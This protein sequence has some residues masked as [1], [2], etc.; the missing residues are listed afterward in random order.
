MKTIIA[1]CLFLALPAIAENS[2]S[3]DQYK[4]TGQFN[5]DNSLHT[6]IKSDT[7]MDFSTGM[8]GAN[9]SMYGIAR[10]NGNP[11]N[12]GV[13]DIVGVHGTAIKHGIFWAAGMH[14][15]VYDTSPGGT[16]VCLNVEFPQT[17]RGTNTIGINMQPHILARDLV[18]MQIQNP[19]AFRYSLYI[20]NSSIAFGQVDTVPFGMR[21]NTSR[22]SLEFFRSI[23]KPDETKVGEIKMDFGQAH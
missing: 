14:C 1:L 6:G 21:F 3:Q 13:H 11:G 12:W 23:G 8:A 16:S 22:Q 4:V 10:G 20:P 19:E 15:D 17:Q 5:A 9:F 2:A 18:G 7:S